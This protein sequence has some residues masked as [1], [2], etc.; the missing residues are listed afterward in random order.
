MGDRFIV[1][2][3]RGAMAVASEN[4]MTSFHIAEGLGV[5]EIELDVHLSKDG[6]L[7]VMHDDTVDRTTNGSG[8]I[9]EKTWSEL[10]SLT[11][12][13]EER[14]PLLTEV[15]AGIVDTG[16]QIEVKAPSAAAV[17]LDVILASGIKQTRV[18][19][20]SFHVDALRDVAA[21]PEHPRI[22]LICGSNDA[23]K[24]GEALKIG[25]DQLLVHWD[26]IDEVAIATFRKS[27]G[28]LSV[29]PCN[30][31]ETVRRAIEMGFA[32]TTSDDP[33]LALAVRDSFES[34]G[35]R[36]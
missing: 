29:W 10:A 7:V 21:I 26:L 23:W 13:A 6:Q 22:G 32:G 8:A 34:G 18:L 2:G 27:G 3:H 15:I 16:L 30:D 11:V 36:S 33:A 9:A 4:T 19:L 1:T 20:T 17:V 12:G 25:V 35:N 28:V 5:D 14:I 31:T 24:I